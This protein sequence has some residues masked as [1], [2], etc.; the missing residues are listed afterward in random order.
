MAESC[1]TYDAYFDRLRTLISLCQ[2]G[3]SRDDFLL[4]KI[5]YSIRDESMS[6]TLSEDRD[7]TL[8]RAIDKCRLR[9][10]SDIQMQ[11]IRTPPE[12]DEAKKM[13]PL[14]PNKKY[15]N[16]SLYQK[17]IKF[18]VAFSSTALQRNTDFW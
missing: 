18:W 15:D 7:I 10:L 13:K 2:Y 3:E 4:D 12:D 1:E 9:E 17:F 6:K 5:I 11:K 8:E 14:T 16:Q